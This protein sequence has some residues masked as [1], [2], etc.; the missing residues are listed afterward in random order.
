MKHLYLVTS[1]MNDVWHR[2]GWYDEVTIY[3]FCKDRDYPIMH[4]E[5]GIRDYHQL[6][7]RDRIAAREHLNDLF[8]EDEARALQDCLSRFKDFTRTHITKVDLPLS[9]RYG[10][11]DDCLFQCYGSAGTLLP[12]GWDETA[13][14]FRVNGF[15]DV[16]S[17]VQREPTVCPTCGKEIEQGP[18][19]ADEL[20]L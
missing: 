7:G 5:E 20:L 18:L 3:W 13:L 8:S 4:P 11:L 15:Y 1:K 16:G 12:G 17:G 14:P 6:K 19:V 10:S 9:G 2:G